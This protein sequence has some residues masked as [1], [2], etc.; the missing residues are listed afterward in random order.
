MSKIVSYLFK[1]NALRICEENKPFWYTSRK[2]W[3]LLYKHTFFI[4]K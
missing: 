4:W 1:T 3:T 2:N